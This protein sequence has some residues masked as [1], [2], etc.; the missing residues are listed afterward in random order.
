VSSASLPFVPNLSPHRKDLD[1]DQTVWSKKA[2]RE[3]SRLFN[4]MEALCKVVRSANIAFHEGD[5]FKAYW[6]MLD[7]LLLFNRLNNQKAIGVASNNLGNILLVIYRTLKHLKRNTFNGLSLDTII[8]TGTSNYLKAITLGEAAYDEF[9]EKEGWSPKCLEFM[10]NLANRYFNRGLFFLTLHKDHENPEYLEIGMR[11]LKIARDMDLEVVSN[12]EDSGWNID[13]KIESLFNTAINRVSGHNV[14]LEMG[15]QDVWE[16]EEILH[17][18]LEVLNV[19]AQRPSSNL[20]RTVTLAG[21]MQVLETQI[22]KY[23]LL[24]NDHVTAAQVAVRMLVEDEYI[25]ADAQHNALNALL[26]YVKSSDLEDSS[27]SLLKGILK[28][29][30]FVLLVDFEK[31]LAT[32]TRRSISVVKSSVI[33][34]VDDTKSTVRTRKN[35]TC[36]IA[37]D[38]K[39]CLYDSFG[40]YV[41]MENF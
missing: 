32:I 39:L 7:A 26:V 14:L 18:T 12:G 25:F 23:K 27:K 15:Y 8:K 9:F 28:D 24:K 37:Q 5:L 40:Q 22:I 29:C 11:D 3:V 33:S 31:H 36:C 10:Q 6:I 16:T 13:E 1:N 20:F 4:T 17:E 19:E 41:T 35:S 2:S 30:R 38:P 21:R 34:R